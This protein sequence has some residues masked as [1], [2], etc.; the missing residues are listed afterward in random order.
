VARWQHYRPWL[1][2]L[3]EFLADAERNSASNALHDSM[4]AQSVAAG[5][6]E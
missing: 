1:G 3:E 2:E 5:V 4:T 6:M